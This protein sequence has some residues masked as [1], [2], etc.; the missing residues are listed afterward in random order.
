[1]PYLSVGKVLVLPFNEKGTGLT[2]HQF[3]LTC[4]E[5]L[6]LSFSGKGVGLIFQ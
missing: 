4:S 6:V 2:F 3:A 5:L 1:M